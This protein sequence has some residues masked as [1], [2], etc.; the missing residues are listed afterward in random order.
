MVSAFAARDAASQNVLIN[1]LTQKSGIASIGGIIYLEVTICNTS[2]TVSVPAYKLRP[3]ISVPSSLIG[4]PEA[5]HILPNGWSIISNANGVI[6][7]SNGTDMIAAN[8]CRTILIA[9]QGN[10]PGGPSTISGNLMF[11]N[12]VAPGSASGAAT[13]GDNAADNISTSTCKI[14][15]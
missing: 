9:M 3:Q 12:G 11:S 2:A 6:R 14:L 7:L 10:S 5:G 13:P 8:D 1:V 4:L 15:R